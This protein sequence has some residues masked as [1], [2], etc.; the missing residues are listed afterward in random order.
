MC[1]LFKT[2]STVVQVEWQCA[3]SGVAV[4]VFSRSGS[5]HCPLFRSGR[6]EKRDFPHCAL[7][8]SDWAGWTSLPPTCCRTISALQQCALLP[9]QLFSHLA[10]KYYQYVAVH[11]TVIRVSALLHIYLSNLG[12][13]MCVQHVCYGGL[14]WCI[15][16]YVVS[17][18]GVQFMMVA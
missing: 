7:F 4:C 1:P 5:L 16:S 8:I 15:A 10:S 2:G 3:L 9:I 17:C 6:E 11:S 18:I 14:L 12:S 13:G